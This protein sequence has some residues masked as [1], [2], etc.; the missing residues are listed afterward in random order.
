MSLTNVPPWLCLIMCIT[1]I[2]WRSYTALKK[3][4][5]ANLISPSRLASLLIILI[6]VFAAF[7]TSKFISQAMLIMLFETANFIFADETTSQKSQPI[8]TIKAKAKTKKRTESKK[9][10]HDSGTKTE[11]EGSGPKDSDAAPNTESAARKNLSETPVNK[12]DEM[13]FAHS[14]PLKQLSMMI[15]VVATGTVLALARGSDTRIPK[16]SEFFS[17][18]HTAMNFFLRNYKGGPHLC[19]DL[20][21]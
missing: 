8:E 5:H 3:G 2:L 11:K 16:K 15:V 7:E 9:A 10:V 21:R 18:P 6:S 20:H 4:T 13:T 12:P 14:I 17:P 19:A 1:L